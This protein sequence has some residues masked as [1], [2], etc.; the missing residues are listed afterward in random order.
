M[1]MQTDSSCRDAE[2]NLTT[3]FPVCDLEDVA[4]FVVLSAVAMERLAAGLAMHSHDALIYNYWHKDILYLRDEL[5]YSTN[6]SPSNIESLTNT[7][8]SLT[9]T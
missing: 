4:C 6:R 1:A 9:N 2:L 5:M 7:R 3:Q 8:E